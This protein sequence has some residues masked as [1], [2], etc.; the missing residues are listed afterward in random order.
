MEEYPQATRSTRR[1]FFSR[2]Q[3]GS[4]L[5]GWRQNWQVAVAGWS[6]GN[7]QA[8]WESRNTVGVCSEGEYWRIAGEETSKRCSAAGAS[9][10]IIEFVPRFISRAPY[11]VMPRDVR[12]PGPG[13]VHRYRHGPPAYLSPSRCEPRMCRTLNH[14]LPFHATLFHRICAAL[15]ILWIDIG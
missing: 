13:R 15:N 9:P 3:K 8:G 12:K 11:L 7:G 14:M 1:R 2:T 4:S 5:P 10:E 6:P